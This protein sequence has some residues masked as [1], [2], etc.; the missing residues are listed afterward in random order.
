MQAMLRTA[1]RLGAGLEQ[2]FTQVN[3]QLAE[4]LP[5]GHFVS[6]IMGLFDPATH[7]LRYLSGSQA[8]FLHYRAAC[9][10]CRWRRA[11]P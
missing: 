9:G 7:E 1:F 2:V 5:N 4:V 6:A 10:C 11:T 3:D 8:P